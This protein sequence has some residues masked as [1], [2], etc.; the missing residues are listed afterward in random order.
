MSN[1]QETAAGLT[2]LWK[3]CRAHDRSRYNDVAP[4]PTSRKPPA[5]MAHSRLIQA[6]H[7]DCKQ[8]SACSISH[9]PA[10]LAKFL[11]CC[12]L[13]AAPNGV[14]HSQLPT[15]LCQGSGA[16]YG[17]S[18]LRT[19]KLRHVCHSSGTAMTRQ[20]TASCRRSIHHREISTSRPVVAIA[21]L[22]L[23]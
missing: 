16:W 17:S 13:L 9:S 10:R 21:M 20:I 11:A 12:H 2:Y 7:F 18:G 8:A 6:P 23:E 19:R 22:K 5:G 1:K 14:R 4:L 15:A 3:A